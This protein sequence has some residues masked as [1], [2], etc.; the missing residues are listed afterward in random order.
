VCL[1]FVSQLHGE[2]TCLRAWL[3]C[4]CPELSTTA[5]QLLLIPADQ[6]LMQH[7]CSAAELGLVR[8]VDGL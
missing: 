3:P 4:W 8:F 1:V 2:R 5:G 7:F 6:Q